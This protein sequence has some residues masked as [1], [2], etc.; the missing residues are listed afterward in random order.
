[1]LRPGEFIYRNLSCEPSIRSIIFALIPEGYDCD[2][3]YSFHDDQRQMV[4]GIAVCG[5]ILV[6]FGRCGAF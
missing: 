5:V 1:M 3:E 6:A 4:L 2:R